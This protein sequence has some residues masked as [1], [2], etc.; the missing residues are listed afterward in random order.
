[1]SINASSPA[2]YPLLAGL[3]AGGITLILSIIRILPPLT[4]RRIKI[5]Q[6]YK[7]QAENYFY[8]QVKKKIPFK[9]IL[10]TKPMEDYWSR[11]SE[12]GKIVTNSILYFFLSGFM[13]ILGDILMLINACF[14]ILD[15]DFMLKI[16][17]ACIVCC[18][19][20]LFMAI[21]YFKAIYKEEAKIRA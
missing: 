2:F 18:M 15:D 3:L 14:H 12:L 19:L 20:F 9:N 4:T 5:T 8:E 10:F 7:T 13:L 16:I 21:I 6:Y 17:L 1:M 11:R